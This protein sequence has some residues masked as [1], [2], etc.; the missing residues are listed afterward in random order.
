MRSLPSRIIYA[1]DIWHTAKNKQASNPLAP[2]YFI[3]FAMGF[4][5]SQNTYSFLCNVLAIELKSLEIH[6]SP[7]ISTQLKP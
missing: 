6:I 4:I 3:A 5:L 7:I 2:V 1:A